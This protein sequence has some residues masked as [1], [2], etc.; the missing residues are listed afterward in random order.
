MYHR[1]ARRPPGT[2][3][4]HHYVAPERFARH[5]AA[6][7]RFGFTTCP[8]TE[9]A[10]W[11]Q[12]GGPDGRR[13]VLTFD[14]GYA[15]FAEA[16]APT[17]ERHGLRG[18]V[19]VVTG[20][21][22]GEN[23]WDWQLGDVHERLMTAEQVRAVSAAGHEVGSHTVSHARLTQVGPEAAQREVTDS[24]AALADLLAQEPA[25]FCYP[26]G[27]HDA[28]VRQMVANAGYRLACSVEKGGNDSRTDPFRWTRINVRS[29]TSTPVLFWKLWRQAK[30][31][32]R[33]D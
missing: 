24:R 33:A 7:A 15:N 25:T 12:G 32:A 22:G 20:L 28:G 2:T 26:Y 10:E 18:T 29:D 31:P 19:F 13:V 1:L 11:L 5:C 8:L 17:M 27:A 16:A 6:L 21:L 9:A 14:D 4:P 30:A 23:D 3:V